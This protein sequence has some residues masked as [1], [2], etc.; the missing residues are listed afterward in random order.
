MARIKS[1][2][3]LDDWVK[4]PYD[5]L[6][7]SIREH[8]GN[9]SNEN[10]LKVCYEVCKQIEACGDSTEFY[11]VA[12]ADSEVPVGLCIAIMLREIVISKFRREEVTLK[13]L[14][15]RVADITYHDVPQCFRTDSKLDEVYTWTNKHTI[16]LGAAI[17]SRKEGLGLY[18]R[19]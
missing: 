14:Y 10:S 12:G 19:K 16:Y 17:K 9:M 6:M 3:V 13:E 18:E 5:V 11:G 2:T 7:V 1:V 15:R 8:I 4:Q